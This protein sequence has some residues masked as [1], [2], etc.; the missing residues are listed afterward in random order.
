[1]PPLLL[2]PFPSRV[3]LN[4]APCTR[5]SLCL[6]PRCFP[7]LLCLSARLHPLTRPSPPSV[8]SL[9]HSP[10]SSCAAAVV[11]PRRW[12]VALARC[13]VG[14]DCRAPL[15]RLAVLSVG[16]SACACVSVCVAAG[17]CSDVCEEC[18]EQASKRSVAW[19]C[20]GCGLH[21]V[22]LVS[23]CVSLYVSTVS[24]LLRACESVQR[25]IKLEI[26]RMRPTHRATRAATELPV[27]AAP[28]L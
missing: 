6:H 15:E 22:C 10:L 2:P 17:V 11:C 23:G 5:L 26:E 18:S 14:C 9:A 13:V 1:M 27:R 12:R 20:C 16:L 28:H 21:C 3:A 25:S 8:C 19:C 4:T 24:V 7:H